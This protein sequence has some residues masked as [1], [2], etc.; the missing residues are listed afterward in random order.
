M[1]KVENIIQLV[2]KQHENRQ[3]ISNQSDHINY[4][5]YSD[6]CDWIIC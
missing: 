6:T 2:E 1:S 3:E 4:D 5:D